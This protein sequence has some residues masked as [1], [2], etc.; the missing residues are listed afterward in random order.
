M[1]EHPRFLFEVLEAG[2]WRITEWVA[3]DDMATWRRLDLQMRDSNVEGARWLVASG[4]ARTAP[5]G[6]RFFKEPNDG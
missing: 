6:L 5:L 4:P 3:I 1:P 2:N